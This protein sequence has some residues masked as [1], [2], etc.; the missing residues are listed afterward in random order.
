MNKGKL[1]SVDNL[2]EELKSHFVDLK[3]L[4]S[5]NYKEGFISGKKLV[6][7]LI[8]E[9]SEEREAVFIDKDVKFIDSKQNPLRVAIKGDGTEEYGKKIIEYFRNIGMKTRLFNGTGKSMYYYNENNIMKR[10]EILPEGYTEISLKEEE[11]LLDKDERLFNK[12]DEKE[13]YCTCGNPSSISLMSLP[14]KCYDCRMPFKEDE[15]P[16]KPNS[17]KEEEKEECDF[18]IISHEAQVDYLR[19]RLKWLEADNAALCKELTDLKLKLK[20]LIK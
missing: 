10:S 14:S 20:D 16:R 17:L 1:I 12:E 18:D 6:L 8:D 4:N 19:N 5:K 7:D 3:Y 15:M 11:S 2:K 9:L 13:E